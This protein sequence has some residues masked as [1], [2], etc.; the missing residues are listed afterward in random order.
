MRAVRSILLYSDALR[1]LNEYR[2]KTID[3]LLIGFAKS[4]DDAIFVECLA[5]WTKWVKINDP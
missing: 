2:Y 5:E 3:P 4:G 1:A